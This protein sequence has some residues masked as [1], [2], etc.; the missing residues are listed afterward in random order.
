MELQFARFAAR[1]E[2]S[3][4]LVANLVPFVGLARSPVRGVLVELGSWIIY[5][6]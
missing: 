1:C 5:E 6:I 2:M 3:W 4:Q